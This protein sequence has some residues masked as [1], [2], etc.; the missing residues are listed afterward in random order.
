MH[1]SHPSALQRSCDEA[2]AA[3]TGAPR[4]TLAHILAKISGV[5]YLA[6]GLL[7]ICVL[8]MRNGF[9]ITGESAC[10]SPE[11]FNEEYGRKLAYEQAISKAWAFEGYLLREQIHCNAELLGSMAF[12][13]GSDVETF[14]G[15]KVVNARPLNRRDYNTLRGWEL[16]ADENGDDAGYLVEYTDRV[17]APPHVPGFHGYVSWSPKDV[18]ERAYHRA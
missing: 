13:P 4:V 3:G 5:V 1:N 12:K 6:H 11:N 17:E 9:T 14:I 15:T 10:A 8:T 16:P 18:F 2:Q 7:T